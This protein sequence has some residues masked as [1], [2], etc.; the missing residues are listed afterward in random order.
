MHK[1]GALKRK[2]TN[3]VRE[4][5]SFTNTTL[6]VTVRV[7]VYVNDALEIRIVGYI[8]RNNWKKSRSGS[9]QWGNG[10]GPIRHTR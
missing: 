9:Y 8:D 6:C 7:R 3:Y 10:G 4:E 2:T 5:K 1:R